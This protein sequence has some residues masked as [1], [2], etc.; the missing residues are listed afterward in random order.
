MVQYLWEMFVDAQYEVPSFGNDI[1][2]FV[3]FVLQETK[4]YP[5]DVSNLGFGY[6]WTPDVSRLPVQSFHATHAINSP[7]L[8]QMNVVQLV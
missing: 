4:V 8:T 7:A 6:D 1:P 2:A 3:S 5:V